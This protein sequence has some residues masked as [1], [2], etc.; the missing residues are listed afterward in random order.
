MTSKTPKPEWTARIAEWNADK[1]YGWLQWG[2]KRVFLHR[3]DLL[4][5]TVRRPAVGEQVRFILGQ[6]AQGRPCATNVIL[7][8]GSRFG[9][10]LLSLAILSVLLVLPCAALIHHD[11][12][13]YTTMIYMLVISGLTFAAYDGDKHRALT[14]QW[15]IPEAHL[16]LLELL[17]GWPVA[18]IAQNLLRHKCSKASYQFVFWLIILAHQFVAFDSMQDW[19]L[20]KVLT[21]MAIGGS[22]GK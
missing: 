8:R 14:N 9:S 1:G 15:R 11:M 17:G 6:D 2:N 12:E 10:G 16:H 19:H 22:S 18:W 20:S 13:V 3:R 7:P 5:G 4:P 21:R